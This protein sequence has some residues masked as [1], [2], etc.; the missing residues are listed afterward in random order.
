MDW[1]DR[2]VAVLASGPSLRPDDVE[3]IRLSG[4]TTIAV[5]STWEVAPFCDVLYAGDHRWW[6]ANAKRVNIPAKRFSR[7]SNSEKK[8]GA[9]YHKTQLGNSF[10]SGQLAIEFALMRKAKRIIMLGYDCSIKNGIHHHG[11]HKESP[12]PNI[13]RCSRWK[14]QFLALRKL[15]KNADIIN[16]SR[17]TEID[18]F[19]TQD[20]ETALASLG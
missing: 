13:E 6:K 10:N 20:L 11:A 7:S 8:F 17:Y 9:T 14:K 5:N 2:T 16:C 12:N 1:S 19:P 18:C 3:L 15:Y 4:L